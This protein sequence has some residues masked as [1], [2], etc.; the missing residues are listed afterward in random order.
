MIFF[1]KEFGPLGYLATYS[2]HGFFK[3]GI[4]W[5]T[6]EHFYQAQKF[7]DVDIRMKIAKAVTPKEASN[8]GRDRSLPIIVNWEEI[9]KDV[10]LTG[11][12]EKFRQNNDILYK[13]ISTCDEE[14]VEETTKE[15]FWGCGPK[16]DGE[17]N[18]GKLL[19]VAREILRNELQ[20]YFINQNI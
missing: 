4:W 16:K 2:N 14:I 17:N 5:K 15:N 10:M 3:D 13:L 18:Y 20:E 6:T 8:I 7:N 1:Y 11:I 12:L 9:K 19:M